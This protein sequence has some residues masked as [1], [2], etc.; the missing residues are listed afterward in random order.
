MPLGP[1]GGT[2]LF[3]LILNSFNPDCVFLPS[4]TSSLPFPPL[5]FLW[6]FTSSS[7]SPPP[8]PISPPGNQITCYMKTASR[9]KSTG[10][11]VMDEP[12][13]GTEIL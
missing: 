1:Y 7:L 6:A 12:R 8:T 13:R 4:P 11:H 9:I 5:P 10:S 3:A 2:K